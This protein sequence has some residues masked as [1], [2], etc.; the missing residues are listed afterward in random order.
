MCDVDDDNDN[1]EGNMLAVLVLPL[2]LRKAVAR[3]MCK[4]CQKA[5]DPF[6]ECWRKP[7]NRQAAAT[8]ATCGNLL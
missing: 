1:K 4:S 7:R 6:P 3:A 5:H 8:F 2:E